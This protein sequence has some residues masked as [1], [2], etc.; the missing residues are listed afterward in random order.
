METWSGESSLG[1]MQNW[2]DD[3][4]RRTVISDSVLKWEVMLKGSVLGIVAFNESIS[5]LAD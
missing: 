3:P 5:Q 4:I 2:V 1:N